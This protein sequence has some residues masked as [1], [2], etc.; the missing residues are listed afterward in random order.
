MANNLSV[1][2]ANAASKVLKTTDNG[3][4]HTPHHNVDNVVSVVSPPIS[5]AT[6]ISGQIAVPTA[7]TPV[8]GGDVSLPNGVILKAHP[9]NAG[10]IWVGISGVSSSNGFPLD[11][12]QIIPVQVLNLN[13]LYFNA[14]NSGDKICWIK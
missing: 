5:T 12:G 1:K 7:G 3:G 2:D 8:Q 9:S 6:P 14:S 4:V 10:A 11:A 13:E